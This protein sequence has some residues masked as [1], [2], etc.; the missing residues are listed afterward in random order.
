MPATLADLPLDQLLAHLGERK[1]TGT[2]S[3]DVPHA[4]KKLFLLDGLLAGVTSSNP[5]ELLGHFL[6]GWGLVREEQVAEA[7]RLQE[8]LGTPLGRILERMGAIDSDSLAQALI[9]QCEEAV[10][11][12]FL[13]PPAENQHFAENIVPIDRPLVLRR[14][15][16]PLVL[17]GLRRGDRHREIRA[18][19]TSDEVILE[20]LEAPL[21]D[22]LS[23]RDR[24]ILA[25]IDGQNS[26]EALAL[27][28]HLV[29]FHVREL[30]YRGLREGFVAVR[31]AGTPPPE[32]SVA[33][34]VQ[35]GHSA[36]ARG[37]LL[38]AWRAA[39]TLRSAARSEAGAL[40]R[41]I[42]E[43]LGSLRRMRQYVPRVPDP[44]PSLPVGAG[45]EGAFVVSR[46][47]GRWTLKEIQ[48]I[49]PLEELHYWVIVDALAKAGILEIEPPAKGITLVRG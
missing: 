27:A 43:K 2:L 26:L 11:D 14:P 34:A 6:V 45:A 18:V 30:A 4:R 17:E 37:D 21:P 28:C 49:T 20:R 33:A 12:L 44:P 39:R 16:P 29:P 36:L 10:L 35:R 40:V 5:R 47:N 23:M 19:I 46:V 25:A 9:A 48:R 22:T 38:E 15:L 31:A 41:G 13:A 7:M 32:A 42:E 3:V 1:A 8:Q 24:L